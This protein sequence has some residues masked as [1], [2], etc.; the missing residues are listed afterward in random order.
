MTE[1][2]RWFAKPAMVPRSGA[3]PGQ[4]ALE[5]KPLGSLEEYN[6]RVANMA[7]DERK[8]EIVLAEAHPAEAF[9]VPGYCWIDAMTVSFE[10]DAAPPGS[11]LPREPNWREQMASALQRNYDNSPKDFPADPRLEV[12]RRPPGIGAKAANGGT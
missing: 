9:T 1:P 4:P 11:A 12:L 3:L 8:L 10:M 2:R 6:R 5:W 7:P